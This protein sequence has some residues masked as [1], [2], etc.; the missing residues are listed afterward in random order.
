MYD[1]SFAVPLL[2]VAHSAGPAIKLPSPRRL[3]S[4]TSGRTLGGAVTAAERPV[5]QA[6]SKL[7][8]AVTVDE[9]IGTQIFGCTLYGPGAHI[10]SYDLRLA[11]F[12]VTTA[13]IH[14][15]K[16]GSSS[17]SAFSETLEWFT[18]DRRLAERILACYPS[19]SLKAAEIAL[20]E[21]EINRDFWDLLPYVLEPHGH[22]T[23]SELEASE[24]ARAT[25]STKKSTGVYYTPSDVADFM[26][27]SASK[28]DDFSG[29][30][31]DPA[32][33]TGVFLRAIV[34]QFQTHRVVGTANVL[35]FVQDK[36]FAI[37]KSA[38]ATDLA[39][40]V[41][42]SECLS[43]ASELHPPIFEWQ[44]I[45][46]NI[47]CMDSLRI[48]PQSCTVDM[49]AEKTECISIP[50]LFPTIV[51][52]VFDH[53][54][55]N[56]PY[57]KIQ[58]DQHIKANWH[59]YSGVALGGMADTQLGFT[60][61]LWKFAGQE[62]R[63]V[64]VLPLSI[65]T[66]TTKAYKSLRE[67]LL[68]SVGQKDF[69][70]FD[71][72]PQALF[73]E[74]IKTRNV[75]IVRQSGFDVQNSLR[76]SRLLKWTAPQR[77]SIFTR[78][79]AVPVDTNLCHSFI[80]K[81]GSPG[82]A[83]LYKS[84]QATQVKLTAARY[85]P[86]LQ[87][88]MLEEALSSDLNQE[89]VLISATAYNFINCFYSDALPAIAAQDYSRSPINAL[90]FPRPSDASAAFSILSSRLCF[91]LWHVEGD[92]FHLT[93]DFLQRL[94]IWA[95]MRDEG[96]HRKLVT[97]GSQLWLEAQR[98]AVRSINGGKQTYSFHA[99]HSHSLTLEIDRLLSDAL[100]LG[101]ETSELLDEFVRSTVSID[102]KCRARGTN[103]VTLEHP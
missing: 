70:F 92:G 48:S 38:L 31:L 68:T 78:N 3:S 62:S 47:I 102:G 5:R 11:W 86:A 13:L 69:L 18:G 95:V 8:R 53:I 56:P 37:D 91:W 19:R 74:D 80:P 22:I 96:V 97:L 41:L 94:P 33:G 7:G 23:R 57:A 6:I 71:R 93:S 50:E 34:R 85:K 100:Q 43:S 16:F 87:R 44:L 89:T 12:I 84:L 90:V 49:H 27:S 99:G 36:L 15:W 67:G 1:R 4:P 14:G 51:D 103:S 66:N 25:R 10:E 65:G 24:V 60:E 79:R 59:S 63:S 35:S 39:S 32:C 81:V 42:L 21:L 76:T 26:V 101:H 98:Y 72:E 73:G 58:V 28:P 82:E 45:K 2:E 17:P 83:K 20:L 61:M 77:T 55:M 29:K 46:K 54:V 75:V 9:S 88:M 30:W 40:L 64:A 52:G